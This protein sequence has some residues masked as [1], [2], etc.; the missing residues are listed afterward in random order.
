MIPK[1]RISSTIILTCFL[2]LTQATMGGDSLEESVKWKL[3]QPKSGDLFGYEI[4][5]SGNTLVVAAPGRDDGEGAVF[6][7]DASTGEGLQTLLS[8]RPELESYFG[9]RVAMDGNLAAVAAPYEDGDGDDQGAVYLIDLANDNTTR[10]IPDDIEDLDLFGSSIALR[11][12]LLLIGAYKADGEG[13][14][15]GAVYI[16]DIGLKEFTGKLIAPDAADGD[17]FGISIALFEK[18]VAVGAWKGDGIE[19]GE[20]DRGAGYLFNVLT[21][22]FLY[23]VVPSGPDVRGAHFGVSSFIS[24]G[25]LAFGAHT[26]LF[27]VEGDDGYYRGAVY[28]FDLNSGD[29]VLRLQPV[30]TESDDA[31]GSSIAISEDLILIG[32]NQAD[33][34]AIQSTGA[35]WLYDLATG[36]ELRRL[37]ASDG[38]ADDQ[39]GISVILDGRRAAIGSVLEDPDPNEATGAIYWFDFAPRPD[40]LIGESRSA[41]RGDN[42]YNTSGAGQRIR[43]RSTRGM[44]SFFSAENDGS[45]KDR[46]RVSSRRSSQK[47][48]YQYRKLSG[49]GANV[50]GAVASGRYLTPVLFPGERID[51]RAT[52]TPRG[53]SNRNRSETVR[54]VIRSTEAAMSDVVR[55]D[56][57]VPR[58]R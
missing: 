43:Q 10:I 23:K 56:L 31:F 49:G 6:L 30:G 2:S 36:R 9:L 53:R 21:G 16:Y 33:E 26:E 57:V 47:F 28:L 4:V 22:E 24:N 39:L 5:K 34:G 55:N 54:T 13:S 46:L 17:E 1:L 40:A 20:I 50:T 27:R 52:A 3:D 15:R 58:D 29:E 12:N 19:V 32:G 35:A 44:R 25:V 37:K 41:L 48:R 18:F 7:L 45:L 42:R 51:F 11:G 14:D 8:P 38:G